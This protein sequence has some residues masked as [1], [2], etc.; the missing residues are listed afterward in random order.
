M[1]IFLR[2]KN[3]EIGINFHWSQKETQRFNGSIKLIIDEDEVQL[4]N[5]I[6]VEDYL[7][8]VISSEMNLILLLNI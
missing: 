6:D 7:L 8:S 1:Q 5:I 4:I 2:L 3:V